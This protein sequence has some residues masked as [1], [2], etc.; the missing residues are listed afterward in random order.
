MRSILSDSSLISQVEA[1]DKLSSILGSLKET[2]IELSSSL[3][4]ISSRDVFSPIDLPS[5]SR[6]TVDGYA[7]KSLCTPG[8]FSLKG[9]VN[10]GESPQMKV[11]SCEDVVEVDTGSVIPEGADAVVKIEDTRSEDGKIII[12]SKVDFG[13]NVGWIGS[14]L[15]QGLKCLEAIPLSRQKLLV[16]FQP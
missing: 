14:D 16:F 12:P 15:P 6:S 11:E 2:E 4:K 3:G 5:F 13:S 10:I 1:I 7:V 9:K 8:K